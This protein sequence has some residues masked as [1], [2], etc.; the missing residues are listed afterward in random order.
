[1]SDNNSPTMEMQDQMNQMNQKPKQV[2]AESEHT[3][4]TAEEAVGYQRLQ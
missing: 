1:M 4:K 2:P 3:V